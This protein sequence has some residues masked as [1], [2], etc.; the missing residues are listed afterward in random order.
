MNSLVT[1]SDIAQHQPPPP[2]PL[3]DVLYR[4]IVLLMDEGI[5]TK[6]ALAKRL[7]LSRT[8]IRRMMLEPRFLEIARA[9]D[10]QYFQSVAEAKAREETAAR[11]VTEAASRERREASAT[12]RRQREHLRYLRRK[13]GHAAADRAPAAASAERVPP[14]SPQPRN[15]AQAHDTSPPEAPVE[16]ADDRWEIVN[17][18]DAATGRTIPVKRLRRIPG[19]RA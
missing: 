2:D 8:T 13:A 3:K 14:V 4:R 6:I 12:R 5:R 1:V 19:R 18:E 7:G 10:E 16:R 11:K 17:Y 9:Y 15:V